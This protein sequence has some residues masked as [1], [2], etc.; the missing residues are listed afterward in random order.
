MPKSTSLIPKIIHYCWFGEKELPFAHKNFIKNWQ[1]LMPDYEFKLWTEKNSPIHFPYLSNALRQKK[2]A[3]MSNF[4]R[5]YALYIEGGIYLDTDI[6]VL[7]RFDELLK[8][9]CFLGIENDDNDKSPMIN[10]AVIGAVPKNDFIKK[11]Q[12]YLLNRYDGSEPANFSSPV[13]VTHLI[14]KYGYNLNELEDKLGIKILSKESFYPYGWQEEYSKEAITPDTIAIHH[15]STS[16]HPKDAKIALLRRLKILILKTLPYYLK[17]TVSEYLIYGKLGFSLLRNPT[18]L[19]GPFSGLKYKKSRSI[20]SKLLP[21]L[22][23]TYE[24]CLHVVLYELSLLKYHNIINIGC[25][26]GYYTLGL[27]KL[28]P[29][30]K[31]KAYDSNPEAISLANENVILNGL[32]NNIVLFNEQF[33]EGHITKERVKGRNLIFCDA[34]GSENKI[35][36]SYNIPF[37]KDADL[38]IEL[39][40]FLVLGTKEKL[41]TLFSKTHLVEIVSQKLIGTPLSS[42]L[43]KD[44]CMQKTIVNIDEGRPE[45]MEWLVLRSKNHF[46]SH[47]K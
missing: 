38:I 30:A 37:L 4:V 42:Y 41:R 11:C 21:K 9:Q 10:N 34:E 2:W 33:S 13:L 7:K 39:H 15:W 14:R 6:E 22:I 19:S 3:N 25:G 23:G 32:E 28:F 44:K 43:Q 24:E 47:E 1:K 27:A 5:L 45:P 8:F 31:I 16:W 36:S 35:F 17:N 26:E 29:E 40:D 12:V 20:G 18:V 46:Q